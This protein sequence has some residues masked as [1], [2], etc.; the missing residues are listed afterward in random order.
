MTS[1]LQPP[2]GMT[3]EDALSFAMGQYIRA[4]ANME[5]I[6]GTHIGY[7]LNLE[8][9]LVFFILKDILISQKIK[10]LKRSADQQFGT[11]IA[12]PYRAVLNK[13]ENTLTFR[14]SLVHG[15]FVATWAAQGLVQGKLGQSLTDLTAG[16][17]PIGHDSLQQEIQ[18]VDS[19]A[20][21]LISAFRDLDSKP[22]S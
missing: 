5:T 17:E 7:I 15:A 20:S 12:A 19:L 1:S 14:N 21:E 6:I 22:K 9:K 4:F 16:M 10:L 13:V 11:V 18:T 3:S 8:H 2:K